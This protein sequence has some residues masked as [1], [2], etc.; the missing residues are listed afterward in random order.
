MSDYEYVNSITLQVCTSRAKLQCIRSRQLWKMTIVGHNNIYSNRLLK[1]TDPTRPSQTSHATDDNAVFSLEIISIV[2]GIVYN[3]SQWPSGIECIVIKQ[4]IHPAKV[5]KTWL[6]SPKRIY[7]S[8]I[9]ILH[10]PT[11]TP[12]CKFSEDIILGLQHSWTTNSNS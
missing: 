8:V 9:L 11:P 6:N 7:C 5:A 2:F 1:G 12:I 3:S 4:F 10:T